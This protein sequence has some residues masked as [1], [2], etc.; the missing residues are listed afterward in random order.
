MPSPGALQR[1][2]SIPLAAQSLGN[3]TPCASSSCS[4]PHCRHTVPSHSLPL[5][6][7][8]WHALG[9]H[10]VPVPTPLL[11]WWCWK[12]CPPA[13]QRHPCTAAPTTGTSFLCPHTAQAVPGTLPAPQ[14]DPS[15][16]KPHA[17]LPSPSL[18]LCLATSFPIP[19]FP[20]W[21]RAFLLQGPEAPTQ[22]L[23]S[24]EHK[25][26]QRSSL[27]PKNPGTGCPKINSHRHLPKPTASPHSHHP[28]RSLS[29]YSAPKDK[30]MLHGQAL[31][32][33][34]PLWCHTASAQFLV[35]LA[36]YGPSASGTPYTVLP[37]TTHKPTAP[38]P[39]TPLLPHGH[40]T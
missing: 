30:Q 22:L 31:H 23:L 39:S 21:E 37:G 17:L 12:H 15:C 28:H 40:G 8:T 10:S 18:M 16:A 9:A 34:P 24:R 1:Q 38:S 3:P 33:H 19:C 13:L 4:L 32:H 6:S 7:G 11:Q 36:L 2:H 29:S 5:Q 20:F 14:T 35:S 27:A 25:G 26:V